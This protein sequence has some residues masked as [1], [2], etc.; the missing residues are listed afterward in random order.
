M[1][2]TDTTRTD[3]TN[4]LV[5]DGV[6]NTNATAFDFQQPDAPVVQDD[7]AQ[8]GDMFVADAGGNLPT[9]IIV[10]NITIGAPTGMSLDVTMVP[11]EV[12]EVRQPCLGRPTTAF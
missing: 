2:T 12:A 10:S 6:N 5:T 4:L 3:L 1:P 9:A 7:Y 8:Q 11:W